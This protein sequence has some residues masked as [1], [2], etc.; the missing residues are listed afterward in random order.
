MQK[1]I[2]ISGR[3][4]IYSKFKWNEI[5]IGQRH[6]LFLLIRKEDL[7][8]SKLGWQKSTEFNEGSN[9]QVICYTRALENSDTFVIRIQGVFQNVTVEQFTRMY[10]IEEEDKN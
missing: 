7:N 5:G 9:Y 1:I 10:R 6:F 4:I 8:D 2:I 3:L